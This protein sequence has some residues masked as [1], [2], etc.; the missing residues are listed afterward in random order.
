[1]HYVIFPYTVIDRR[2]R[3]TISQIKEEGIVTIQ[4]RV[5]EHVASHRRGMPYRV[6][7]EDETGQAEITFFQ[8]RPDYIQGK[9][10]V[11]EER[12]ISGEVGFFQGNPQLTHPEHILKPDEAWKLNGLEPRYGLTAGLHQKTIQSI[13]HHALQRVPD[14]PEW[15]D[16][17]ILKQQN[18]Q[19][20]KICLTSIHQPEHADE[21]SPESACYQRL[22]YDEFLANQL[23]LQIVRASYKKQPGKPRA[24]KGDLRNQYLKNLPFD[25]T[26]SQ[27]IALQEI[28]E[29]MASSSKMIR[30][31]Q[32][33]VGSGKTVM[34]TLAVLTAVENG[35]QAA[36][37]APTS[38][39]AT[40][41]FQE[42]NERLTEI[43]VRV[44][45]LTGKEK[46]KK[47][48]ANPRRLGIR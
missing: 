9:L 20:W 5:V 42:L 25:L 16:E 26:G 3:P 29:D 28:D 39:L 36:F 24:V 38:I 19:D 34:A 27:Q 41:H 4:V 46:G 31:L 47:T 11:G 35:E 2:Y 15:I 6:I 14:L 1:M 33:D 7:V 44:A 45:I 37:M 12:I 13:Q 40:Q 43:G 23:T 17:G 48:Y 32:G 10:P 22:A 30:L 21:I 18:W 8:A